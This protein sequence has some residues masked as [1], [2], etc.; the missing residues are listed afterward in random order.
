MGT[1][2]GCVCG[3]L[4][5]GGPVAGMDVA[6]L[7]AE[8]AVLARVDAM[9]VARRSLVVAELLRQRSDAGE[10]LRGSG[11]MSSREAKRASRTA[12]GLEKLPRAREALGKGEISP[13]QAEQLASRANDPDRA[14]DVRAHHE[15]ELVE[16]A[17]HRSTDEFGR[18]LRRQ[19]L[20]ASPDEGNSAC[21]EAAA[22]S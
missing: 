17:R 8:I 22:V 15:E 13:G 7:D 4:L 14:K 9:V 5:A 3:G 10:R 16:R 2:T 19:D 18:G 11:G 1:G 20:E 6:A 21:S 12:E